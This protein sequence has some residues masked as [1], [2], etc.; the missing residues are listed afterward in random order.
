MIKINKEEIL[1]VLE[2][3][4]EDVKDMVEEFKESIDE[5]AKLS[6]EIEDSFEGEDIFPKL[7]E[8][9]EAMNKNLEELGV[10]NLETTCDLLTNTINEFENE[11]NMLSDEF[12]K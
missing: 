7:T 9:L 12:K 3:V 1:D 2:D 11:D 5:V 8:E 10:E 4:L 6:V